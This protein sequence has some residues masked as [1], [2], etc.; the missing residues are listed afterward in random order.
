[1][2]K[3]SRNLIIVGVISMVIL[4]AGVVGLSVDWGSVAGAKNNRLDEFAQCLSDAN[5]KMY[6]AYWCPHCQNQ[7]KEFGSSFEKVDYVECSLPGGSGQT[8]ACNQAGIES[9]PTWEFGDG[10]R[11]TGEVSLQTLAEKSGCSLPE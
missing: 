2:E 5:V 4:V 1:M 7:K 8:E 3:S 11:M 6:G 9:Y 10:S